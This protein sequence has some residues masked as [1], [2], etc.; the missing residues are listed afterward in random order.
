MS[1]ELN[2]DLQ[3]VEISVTIHKKHYILKEASGGAVCTYRNA[4]LKAMKP[5][6]DGKPTAMEGLADAE[7]L[8]V[9][10]CLVERK[11]VDGK[12]VDQPVSLAQVRAWPNRVQKT[13]AERVKQISDLEEAAPDTAATLEEKMAELQARR[14]RLSGGEPGSAETASKNSFVSMTA[15]SV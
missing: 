5:G 12:A 15:G 14:D 9:S 7:P 3:P 10:L 11:E 13:L 8:L 1:D 6:P 2:F 4:I